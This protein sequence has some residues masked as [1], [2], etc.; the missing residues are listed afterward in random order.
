MDLYCIAVLVVQPTLWPADEVGELLAGHVR[1]EPDDSGASS[2]NKGR[3]G[4]TPAPSR[5][6]D[7]VRRRFLS[8]YPAPKS[9]RHSFQLHW[10]LLLSGTQGAFSTNSSKSYGGKR[11]PRIGADSCIRV[12]QTLGDGTLV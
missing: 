3:A 1:R 7:S 11:R 8:R 5:L 9:R 4:G 6:R 10:A 12:T 2:R